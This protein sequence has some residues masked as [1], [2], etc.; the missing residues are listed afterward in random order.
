LAIPRLPILRGQMTAFI[1]PSGCGQEFG[2]A[3]PQP[4]ERRDI[5]APKVDPVATRRIEELMLQLRSRSTIAMV[6]H[7]LHEAK[8]VADRTAFLEN[9]RER[10]TQEYV[11]GEFS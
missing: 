3:P 8:R 6:T 1:G 5:Y 7:N 2:P 10:P 9:P 11:R 4:H